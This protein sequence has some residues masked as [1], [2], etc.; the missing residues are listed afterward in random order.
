MSIG[1]G[2][3]LAE[4]ARRRERVLEALDGAVG[5]VFA[6]DHPPPHLGRWEPDWNFYY[7]TGLR[8]EQGAAL[9]LDPG[10]ED[11][12]RRAMLFLKPLNPEMERWDGYRDPIGE[13]LRRR[14]GFETVMRTTMLARTLTA[15]ARKRGRL[16]CL[17]PFAVYDGPVSPD[18]A[19]FKKVAERVVGVR[20]EDRSTLLAQMRAIKSPAELAAMQRAIKATEAGY[21]SAMRAIRPGANERDVQRALEEGFRDGGA[22]GPAYFP[23]VGA[24]LASTVLHYHDNS[25]EIGASDLV[26]IDAGARVG[27]YCADVTRTFPAS[28][29]FTTRQRE[30]YDLVLEALDAATRAARPGKHLH[31]VDA[32]ARAVIERAGLGDAYIHGIGHQLGIEVHDTTPDGPLKEGMVITIEPGV[33][34]PEERLGVRI[35]DDVLI[36]RS[37]PKVLTASIPKRA[38]EVEAMVRDAR[39]R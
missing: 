34:L 39:R 13:P 28:G 35:E 14:L 15:S 4:F 1:D 27:A 18:L 22:D 12:R 29:R 30:V 38:E 8:D 26:L 7:L 25:A 10:A 19:V 31:E 37:K 36:G 32:A 23:I 6:G 24:G 2:I 11:P 21:V 5:L 16:A 3:A 9:L 17:H 20:V 33:Y